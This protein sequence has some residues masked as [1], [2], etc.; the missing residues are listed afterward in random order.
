MALRL[1]VA[2]SRYEKNKNRRLPG[3]GMRDLL[4]GFR[5]HRMLSVPTRRLLKTF[6]TKL[7]GSLMH[8][9]RPGKNAGRALAGHESD[10]KATESGSH[11]RKSPDTFRKAKW[12]GGQANIVIY[13]LSFLVGY[14]VYAAG[15]ESAGGVRR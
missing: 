12:T 14:L 4:A 1:L 11:E 6:Q 10:N 13:A 5:G 2:L 8:S 15:A 7:G 3:W 9:A